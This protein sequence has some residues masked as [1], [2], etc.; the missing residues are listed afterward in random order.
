MNS[1]VTCDCYRR[2]VG[3]ESFSKPTCT[4]TFP[5][6]FQDKEIYFY[7]ILRRSFRN[8]ILSP[9]LLFFFS[10]QSSRGAARYRAADRDL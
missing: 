3:K 6:S 5:R 2:I 4:A 10:A 8:S 9:S 7:N 1:L